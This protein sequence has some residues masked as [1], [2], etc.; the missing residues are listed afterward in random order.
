MGMS[1]DKDLSLVPATQDILSTLG[2]AEKLFWADLALTLRRG[3]VSHVREAS[4]SLAMIRAFQ[5][6]LGKASTDGP[7]L[8]VRLLGT[9]AFF[10]TFLILI[11]VLHTL[12]ASSAITLH[13]EML[14]VTQHKFPDVNVD[15][16]QWSLMTPDGSPLLVTANARPDP[17]RRN[18]SSSSSSSSTDTDD[19]DSSVDSLRSY[20]SALEKKYTSLSPSALNTT[21]KLPHNWTAVH[22]TLTPDKSA[23]F[24]SR[25]HSPSSQ[26]LLFCVPLHGR[27]DADER[28][29]EVHLTLDDAL[30]ELREIIRMSDDGTRRA[31]HV[32]NDDPQA[33]AGWW[34]ER[35]AL[36]KRLQ[37]LLENI[38]FCWLGA[39]KVGA[40]VP[41]HFCV[42]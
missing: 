41:D 28:D 31:A 21:P 1:G 7:L 37:A 22:I 36:D 38:E 20:W 32:R 15:D 11:P 29:E 19:S 14:E 3:T 9:R 26:P 42:S 8:A 27:R 34:A 35:A 10:L 2:D 5:S 12:D 40:F 30:H 33:R 17:R 13:R 16:L 25:L 6:S 24:V 4:V 23:M 39:F 18:P